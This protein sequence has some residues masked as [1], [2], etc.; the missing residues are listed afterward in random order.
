M[1]EEIKT[2]FIK[3]LKACTEQGEAEIL[4]IKFGVSKTS[5]AAYK[6]N[7]TMGRYN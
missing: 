2:L 6:A 1:N 4:A 5:L 3:C 7:M